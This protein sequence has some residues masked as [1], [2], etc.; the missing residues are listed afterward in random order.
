MYIKKS[1]LIAGALIIVIITAFVSVAVVN[2]FG[3][4]HIMDFL[5]F[6][7]VSKAIGSVYYEDIDGKEAANMAI[8]GVAAATGDPYTGFLWGDTARQYMEEVEGDYCGV[9][10]YI[11]YD[12]E[13]NLVSVVSAIAGS[14]AEAAGIGTG[15]K[16]IKIDGEVYAGEEIN[17]AA[18]HMRGE[19]GTDV[20]LTI[21]SA[22]TAA[23]RD[24]TLT[25][26]H[27]EIPS[28]TG[29]MLDDEIG[30]ISISQFTASVSE[31]FKEKYDELKEQGMTSLIIDL[32][33]NPGG[34]LD[35]AVNIASMFINRGEIITYTLDKS[36][37]KEEY[38]SASDEDITPDLNMPVVILINEG[39]ASASEVLSGAMKSYKRAVLLGEKSYGKGIV[40]GVFEIGGDILSVTVSR[41]YT[42]DGVCIHGEGIKPDLEVVMD[43][44]KAAY[45]SS[46]KKE[47]DNQLL[48]AIKFLNME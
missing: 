5:K 26:S 13:Q 14:P 47:E 6:S 36:G 48:A 18:N 43:A 2:P 20:T 29:E 8:A 45:L 10:L 28:V 3:N 46:L 9:G 38:F 12:M 16:I 31:R 35:E 19:E 17:E 11:E 15:D 7:V 42:P 32:R 4:G 23:E 37:D 40:Q 21:R 39:S 27:I 24:V 30:R 41:Y 33:N 44:E 34:L 22:K 25:R 1:R